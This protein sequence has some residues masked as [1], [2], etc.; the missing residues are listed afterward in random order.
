[1]L[2][3]LIPKTK[4][5]SSALAVKAAKG[6]MGEISIRE[7]SR[8]VWLTPISAIT[9]Y[10]DPKVVFERISVVGRDLVPTRSLDEAQL[11]LER[12]GVPSELT[13]ERNYVW[14]SFPKSKALARRSE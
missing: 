7:G 2:E 3:K 13:F 1:M 10:F 4:T 9:F 8:K 14:K 5:E 6:V 12:A 11:V